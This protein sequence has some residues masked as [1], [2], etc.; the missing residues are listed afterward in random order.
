MEMSFIHPITVKALTYRHLNSDPQFKPIWNISG[1]NKLGRL[2]Q[3]VGDQ[4][5]G[6]Y[7]IFFI[8]HAKVPKHKTVTYGRTRTNKI[9]SRRE[10]HQLQWR[11]INTNIGPHH[12]KNP[13]EQCHIN[14]TRRI[15]V[16]GPVNFYLGKP[17]K[18]YE[19]MRLHIS[20]LPEE[21][22]NHYILRAIADNDCVYIEVRGGMYRLPQAGKV[23]HDLLQKRLSNHGHAPIP[24]TPG[25]W[26]YETRPLTFTLVIDHCRVK[27]IGRENAENFKNAL[28]ENYMV[29]TDWKGALY[30]VI[31][32]D[33]D[34]E[35]RTVQLSMP[36]YIQQALHNFQQNTPTRP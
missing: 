31:S 33:W 12:I 25:L 10:S 14:A 21:I 11:H 23:A 2:A 30:C 35:Q 13:L 28:K 9:D 1:A 5:K 27:Y 8:E 26:K 29:S 22:I 18:E 36:N 34:Y 7:T 15:Y 16:L 3:G 20:D 24:N 6:T 19:Y 17:M 4:I 32:L